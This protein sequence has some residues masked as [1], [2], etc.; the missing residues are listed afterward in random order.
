MLEKGF[1]VIGVGYRFSPKVKAPVYIEDAAAAIAWAF[2]HI[3]KYGGNTD[4]LERHALHCAGIYFAEPPQIPCVLM[5][6]L[7][8]DMQNACKNLGLQGWNDTVEAIL[9]EKLV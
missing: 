3:G 7:P 1:A 8:D 6:E 2:Q 4:L 9:R 5:A